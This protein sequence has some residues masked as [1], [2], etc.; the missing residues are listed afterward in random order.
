[1]TPQERQLID[2]LFG[3]L[4]KLETAPRDAEAESA[5]MAGLRRA[6]N[7]VYALVQTALLQDEAL[8]HAAARIEQL[9]A[10]ERPQNQGSFLDSLRGSLFGE[11]TNTAAARGSVPNVPPSSPNA[12]PVWNTGQVLGQADNYADPRGAPGGYGQPGYG[13]PQAQGGGS[14]FLGTAAAAA[15]GMIGGSI[16]MNSFRGLGGLGGGQQQSFGGGSANP[17][18]GGGNDPLARDAGINDIGKNNSGGIEDRRQSFADQAQDAQQDRD[19]DQDQDQDDDDGDFDD[20]GF[21]SDDSD[22]A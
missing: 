21:D 18:G 12:R 5:I 7:A 2:D 14:S 13:A 3:R 9:E 1:M 15:A 22:F 11:N 16:L 17:W 10:G 6:P 8:R 20:A 4:E 19:D